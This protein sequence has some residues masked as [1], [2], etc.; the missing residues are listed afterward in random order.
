M[1]NFKPNSIFCIQI[2][3]NIKL[4]HNLESFVSTPVVLSFGR[5]E[6]FHLSNKQFYH[7]LNVDMF[8]QLTSHNENLAILY[9]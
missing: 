4:V 9:V 2:F 8:W 1:W 5:L 7:I 3:L 6:L